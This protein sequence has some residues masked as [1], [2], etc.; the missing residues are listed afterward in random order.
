M[1]STDKKRYSPTHHAQQQQAAG[2]P[3]GQKRFL[4]QL[5][6]GKGSLEKLLWVLHSVLGRGVC[7]ISI[8]VEEKSFLE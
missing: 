8:E 2:T 7:G 6:E 3:K 4:H 1:D 5:A